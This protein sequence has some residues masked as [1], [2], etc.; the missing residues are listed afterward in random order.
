MNGAQELGTAIAN[1]IDITIVIL[2]DNCYGMIKWKCAFCRGSGAPAVTIAPAFLTHRN[3]GC[4]RL[5]ASYPNDLSCVPRLAICCPLPHCLT[6]RQAG[7]GLPE[8]GL[9]LDKSNPDFV[10]LA[11]AYGAKGHRI[12][13]PGQLEGILQHC[14]STTGC[15]HVVEVPVDYASSSHLQVGGPHIVCS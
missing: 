15:V 3:A 4:C 5:L 10:K 11:E 7:M 13:G 12:T 6:C 8:Y 14:L 1:G 9:D 2:N